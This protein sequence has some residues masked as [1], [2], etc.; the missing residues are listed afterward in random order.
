MLEH[1]HALM[2]DAYNANAAGADSVD[3]D[4]GAD[5]ISQVCRWQVLA[6]MAK[7]WIMADRGQRIINLI[8]INQQL[9]CAPSFAGIAKYVDKVLPRFW[10]KFK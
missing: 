6:A 1:A 5:Q 8:A 4:V 7:L 10:G 3:D 2:Q 9:V